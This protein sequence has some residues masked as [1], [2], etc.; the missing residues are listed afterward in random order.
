MQV[1]ILT[2]KL[3]N[4]G[5]ITNGVRVYHAFMQLRYDVYLVGHDDIFGSDMRRA[6]L[7]LMMGT[8]LY[9]ENVNQVQQLSEIKKD[10]AMLALWYFD[11]CNPNFEHCKHKYHALNGIL[12]YLD[13]LFTTDFSHPWNFKAKNYHHLMQG[14]AADEFK[15]EQNYNEEKKHDVI[16]TGGANGNFAYRGRQI[17]LIKKHFGIDVYGR[18]T[19]RRVFGREFVSAYHNAKVAYVPAP[20]PEVKKKYWSNRV[21]LA[22][23]TGTPCVVGNVPGIE[24]Y[25]IPGREILTFQDNDELIFQIDYLINNPGKAE[26]IGR[27]GRERTLKDHTYTKRVEE[28]MSVVYKED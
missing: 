5:N 18:N 24:N 12:K 9:P 7:I 14:I 28:M 22:A 15:K 20:P 10:K 16:F 19:G 17:E 2:N 11:A 4:Q 21:F 3:D 25:Y 26:K 27:A 23:A 1:A 13:W 8:I 6:D